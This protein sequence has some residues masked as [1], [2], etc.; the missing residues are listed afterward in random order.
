[1]LSLKINNLTD[2]EELA[3]WLL[4]YLKPNTFL[5]LEGELGVG[6]TTFTKLYFF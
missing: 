4:P 6:K 1:M 2:L 5:L 3:K